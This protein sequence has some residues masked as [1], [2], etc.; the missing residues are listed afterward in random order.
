M[1]KI[2]NQSLHTVSDTYVD[3]NK[4][5]PED[6]Y[7][8]QN[9]VAS[10]IRTI[11]YVQFVSQMPILVN[12]INQFVKEIDTAFGSTVERTAVQFFCN[13]FDL[14]ILQFLKKLHWQ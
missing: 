2:I 6:K 5:Y 12:E 7:V 11:G 3:A 13:L 1:I 9:N 10:I 8:Y 4:N 14:V